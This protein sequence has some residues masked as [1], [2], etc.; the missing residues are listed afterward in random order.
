[1]VSPVT[2][3][4]KDLPEPVSQVGPQLKDVAFR[5]RKL[6]APRGDDAVHLWNLTDDSAVRRATPTDAIQHSELLFW[7]FASAPRYGARGCGF[8]VMVPDE[9][10][11]S[12]P[13]ALPSVSSS[14]PSSLTKEDQRKVQSLPQRGG[15][16]G[17]STLLKST[18]HPHNHGYSLCRMLH[19]ARGEPREHEN[20]RNRSL[21]YYCLKRTTTIV[22][23]EYRAVQAPPWTAM[24][25]NNAAPCKT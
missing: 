16:K 6:N 9:G 8:V 15:I 22:S 10:L 4:E 21:N 1:M 25:L 20:K 17:T 12:N 13:R 5:E 19:V 24:R 14:S 23:E 7:N 18:T 2:R 3:I 11:R